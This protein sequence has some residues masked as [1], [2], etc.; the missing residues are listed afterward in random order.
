MLAASVRARLRPRWYD[1]ANLTP[2]KA[3]CSASSVTFTVIGDVSALRGAVIQLRGIEVSSLI[4]PWYNTNYVRERG[5]SLFRYPPLSRAYIE[6]KMNGSRTNRVVFQI[7]EPI[8]MTCTGFSHT[9]RRDETTTEE[10]FKNTFLPYMEVYLKDHLQP[11]IIESISKE[12]I[13]Q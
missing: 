6:T 2:I 9:F 4:C 5:S 12:P 1:L 13:G 7:Q 10:L 8:A 3:D 11:L